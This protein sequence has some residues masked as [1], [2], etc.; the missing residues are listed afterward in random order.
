VG[1]R[2]LVVAATPVDQQR[3]LQY[4]W[5]KRNEVVEMG[6]QRLR[7]GECGQI[8]GKESGGG[9]RGVAGPGYC[10]CRNW[11]IALRDKQFISIILITIGAVEGYI[12]GEGWV[13]F[14]RVTRG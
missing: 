6:K 10:R 2:L 3:R 9:S 1:G 13:V 4:G 7:D 14:H 11:W 8:G 12:Q 5:V